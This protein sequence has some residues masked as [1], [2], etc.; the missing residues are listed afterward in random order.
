MSLEALYPHLYQ[1]VAELVYFWLVVWGLLS[2][3]M[4]GCVSAWAPSSLSQ[5][6]AWKRELGPLA[7]HG[8]SVSGFV[9]ALQLV[10]WVPPAHYSQLAPI[11]FVPFRKTLSNCNRHAS[12]S[13]HRDLMLF[14]IF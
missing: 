10:S 2:A 13:F 9:H 6:V 12:R 5:E 8:W 4:R 7:V 1:Y 11:F 14:Y 3:W